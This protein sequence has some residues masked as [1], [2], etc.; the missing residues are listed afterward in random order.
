[1]QEHTEGRSGLV[2]F[3]NRGHAEAHVFARRE[4]SKTFVLVNHR[5]LN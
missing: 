2:L 5:I 4:G 1:M 3:L